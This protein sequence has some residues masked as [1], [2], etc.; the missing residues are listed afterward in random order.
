MVA[1]APVDVVSVVM[2]ARAFLTSWL[3]DV[4]SKHVLMAEV[5]VEGTVPAAL[6]RGYTEVVG[7]VAEL[8][9]VA[10]WHPEGAEVMAWVLGHR[11]VAGPV[12]VT[13][14]LA[15]LVVV[16]AGQKDLVRFVTVLPT[17]LDKGDVTAVGYV[18]AIP[19]SVV[20]AIWL[21]VVVMVVV[22]GCIMA[23]WHTVVAL[24]QVPAALRPAGVPWQMMEVQGRGV[25]LTGVS[26]VL[27]RTV[28]ESGEPAPASHTGTGT[29]FVSQR[30]VMAPGRVVAVPR[31]V[32]VIPGCELGVVASRSAVAVL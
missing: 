13:L 28:M 29:V 23:V 24:P 4:V 19:F 2:Y 3:G 6:S 1:D 21:K 18:L 12:T 7:E 30:V 31:S 17:L 8:A 14:E 9:F 16:T 5:R 27:S 32:A 22:A 26:A 11:E 20:G 25:A 10:F 15:A